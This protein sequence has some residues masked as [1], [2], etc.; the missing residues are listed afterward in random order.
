[1]CQILLNFKS[2]LSK[3]ILQ[4]KKKTLKCS[5]GKRQV[6][7]KI[8]LSCRLSKNIPSV[9]MSQA[10]GSYPNQ[11]NGSDISNIHKC[12]NR[13]TRLI[14]YLILSSLPYVRYVQKGLCTRDLLRP[15]IPV[16]SSKQSREQFPLEVWRKRW[17]LQL[18]NAL[19]LNFKDNGK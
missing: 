4:G 8:L 13:I 16:M 15:L 9:K 17:V 5:T 3:Q 6:Y 1:M 14:H 19:L 10:K 18:Q 11:Y 12:S 2:G 7:K